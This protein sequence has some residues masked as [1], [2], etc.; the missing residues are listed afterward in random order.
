MS[1]SI[2]VAPMMRGC[3]TPENIFN[4][5]KKII[6]SDF[7]DAVSYMDLNGDVVLNSAEFDQHEMYS[8]CMNSESMMS[9]FFSTID[10]DDTYANEAL[11]DFVENITKED[12]LIKSDLWQSLGYYIR[13]VVPTGKFSSC[14]NLLL[15]L[16]YALSELT[17]GFVLVEYEHMFDLPYGAYKSSDLIERIQVL[18]R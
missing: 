14:R 6:K 5:I 12:L 13:M 16:C 4:C 15:L 3:I 8:V 2:S 17:D 7:F 1:T 9:L 18:V 11:Q 10:D